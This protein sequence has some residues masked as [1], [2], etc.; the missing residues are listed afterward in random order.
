LAAS[1][2]G[3]K[4][5]LSVASSVT[6][7]AT[8]SAY[9]VYTAVCTLYAGAD[10]LAVRM[11]R[12]SGSGSFFSF[13]K[14]ACTALGRSPLPPARRPCPVVSR[15]RFTA[16]RSRTLCALLT[17]RNFEPST[18]IVWP[19]TSPTDR[20]PHNSHNESVCHHL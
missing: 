2:I 20:D 4:L 6:F 10:P 3:N 16:S 8:I 18:A 7:W 15:L 1:A 19:R 17:A 11:K 5:R 13:S 9:P 12:A 14:A